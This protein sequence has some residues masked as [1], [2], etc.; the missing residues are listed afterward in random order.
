MLT[1]DQEV[2]DMAG[3]TGLSLAEC[4]DIIG[5]TTT[6]FAD[7]RCCGCMNKTELIVQR[8]ACE[9]CGENEWISAPT[10]ND[11]VPFLIGLGVGVAFM[12]LWGAFTL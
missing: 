3:R 5:A 6:M 9:C 2:Y 12:T 4:A 10:F 8:R 1:Y 7:Y 11:L